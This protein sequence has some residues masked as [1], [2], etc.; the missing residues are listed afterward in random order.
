MKVET[1]HKEWEKINT[2]IGAY[3]KSQAHSQYKGHPHTPRRRER[4]PRLRG[5]TSV[6]RCQCTQNTHHQRPGKDLQA[7]FV[8]AAAVSTETITCIEPEEPRT[9]AMQLGRGVREAGGTTSGADCDTSED[10][11]GETETDW[12]TLDVLDV[13]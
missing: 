12:V 9:H 11:E 3:L 2:A 8:Y 13:E 5:S 6:L 4:T 1:S 7:Q 10:T